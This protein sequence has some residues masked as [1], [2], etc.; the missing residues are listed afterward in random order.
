[1]LPHSELSVFTHGD[2]ALRNI[3]VDEQNNVT[4]VID[5]EYAG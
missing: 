4:G 3:L 5:W 2:I 1:M